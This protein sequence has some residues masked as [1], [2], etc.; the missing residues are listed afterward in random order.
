MEAAR[1]EYLRWRDIDFATWVN[2]GV[3]LP[4]VD[5]SL[6]YRQPLTLGLMAVVKTWPEPR[7][8]VRLVWQYDIQTQAGDT[9]VTGSVTLVPVDRHQRK[10][11]RQLPTPVDREMARLYGAQ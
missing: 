9:C 1:V 6:Q 10:I 11:L 8:G 5:L 4:V 7:R 2:Y 3:D